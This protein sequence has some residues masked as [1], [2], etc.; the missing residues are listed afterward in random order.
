M[1]INWKVRFNKN[2][3]LFLFRFFAALFVPI[4]AYMG[5]R[6]E[7]LTTWAMVGE[8]FLQFI[9]NPYLVGLTVFNAFNMVPDPIVKGFSD[10][11]AGLQLTEPKSNGGKL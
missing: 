2:N 5:Y 8:V 3:A 9:T 10:S 11:P 4:L 6:V 7:D 1:K